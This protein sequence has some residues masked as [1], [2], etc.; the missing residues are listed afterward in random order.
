MTILRFKVDSPDVPGGIVQVPVSG[1]YN[2]GYA[3]RDQES[4]RAHIREGQDRGV[5]APRTVPALYPLG[6]QGATTET[7][8]SVFGDR[9]YGEVEYALVNSS[10]GWLV[11]VASDH[12]DA[13]VETV[14]VSR[15]KRS[16]PD[17]L[18]GSA[19]LLV[20]VAGIFDQ[21]ELVSEC[22][23]RLDDVAVQVQRDSCGVRNQG[24]LALAA[25]R[26]AGAH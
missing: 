26:P 11:S 1:V 15:A 19:W 6:A 25:S 17:V 23:A 20:D 14:S 13:L 12:S 16:C 5:P 3:G 24:V 9:T 10:C 22:A 7:K 8:I 18:A 21:L 2:F 4:V